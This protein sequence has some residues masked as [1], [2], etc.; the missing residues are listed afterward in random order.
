MLEGSGKDDDDRRTETKNDR[1][2][3]DTSRERRKTGRAEEGE[4]SDDGMVDG[5]SE[6]S[7]KRRRRTAGRERGATGQRRLELQ[8]SGVDNGCYR[9]GTR[10]VRRGG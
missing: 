1:D 2:G 10:R 7:E 4:G 5:K 9:D 6:K 3:N 8:G